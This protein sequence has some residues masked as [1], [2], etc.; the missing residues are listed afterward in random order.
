MGNQLVPGELAATAQIEGTPAVAQ[1]VALSCQPRPALPAIDGREPVGDGT[2][3][4]LVTAAPPP[5]VL[6]LGAAA[7]SG[8]EIFCDD[9][10]MMS[11]TVSKQTGPLLMGE[12]GCTVPCALQT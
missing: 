12:P 6:N 9:P 4:G 7:D 5:T 3:I 8:A 2:V 1:Q 11:P 10:E